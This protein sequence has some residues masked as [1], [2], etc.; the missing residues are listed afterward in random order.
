MRSDDAGD[1][2]LVAVHR[3]GLAVPLRLLLDAHRPMAPLLS[4]AAAFIAPMLGP[5]GLRGLAALLADPGRAATRL[6]EMGGAG[7]PRP[8]IDPCQ[9]PE[10]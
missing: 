5:L 10:S 1:A 7:T 3:R 6:D 8:G 2:L 9:T 4:D